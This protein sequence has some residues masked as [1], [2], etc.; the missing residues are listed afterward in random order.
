MV[1]ME[2][3]VND[4]EAELLS[5][6][7]GCYTRKASNWIQEDFCP[8]YMIKAEE[9]LK[10]EKDRVTHYLHSSTKEKLIEQPL[11]KVSKQLLK[12]EH[13]GCYAL[14]REDKVSLF[15]LLVSFT[16]NGSSVVNQAED[17]TNSRKNRNVSGSQEQLVWNITRFIRKV[18]DLHE[19]Y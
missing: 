5:D 15:S 11:S 8:E 1:N 6:T 13:F 16:S 18:I 14:L 19:K 10:R 2:C 3:Y 17:A 7:A 4:F 12:K 9:C